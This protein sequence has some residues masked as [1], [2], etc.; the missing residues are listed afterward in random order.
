[1]KEGK[2][3]G[4]LAYITKTQLICDGDSCVIAGSELKLK[5]YIRQNNPDVLKRVKIVKAR[6]N[7]IKAALDNGAGYSFDEEAY[8]RFYPL[9]RN[10][11]MNVGPEDF[12]LEKP[13]GPHLVRVRKTY[14]NTN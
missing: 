8:N 10:A 9:A 5:A 3:I 4:Y 2:V 13:T 12:S 14:V 6:F 7:R 1:M 11:G